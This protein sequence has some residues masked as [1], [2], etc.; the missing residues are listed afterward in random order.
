MFISLSMERDFQARQYNLEMDYHLQ[1]LCQEGADMR[2]KDRL[3]A[4][5]FSD[6]E[7]KEDANAEG[8]GPNGMAARTG[9]QPVLPQ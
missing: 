1:F 3:S 8:M 9:G 2:P 4:L 7:P 5:P 6:A